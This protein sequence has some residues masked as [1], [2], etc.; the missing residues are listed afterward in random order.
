MDIMTIFGFIGAVSFLGYGIYEGVVGDWYSHRMIDCSEGGGN[1]TAIVA[2]PE[3]NAYY[4]VVPFN[5]INEGSY[6][7]DSSCAERPVAV[8]EACQA[9][10][11][12][13]CP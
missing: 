9:P 11:A 6:G 8:G 4:L 5:E 10:Q 12:L 13:G 3:G 1:L 7:L 2:M